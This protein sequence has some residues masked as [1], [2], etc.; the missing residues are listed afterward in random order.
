[1]DQDYAPSVSVAEDHL[2]PNRFELAQ[3]YPNPF[4]PSTT[5]SFALPTAS[6]VTVEIFNSLGQ[7]VVVL[8]EGHLAAGE[9]HVL[10]D[11]LGRDG[12]TATTGVYFCRL[13][14]GSFVDTK[15]MLLL[16]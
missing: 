2:V 6:H 5:I 9:H 1:V 7:R 12:K 3:N 13:Q 4:N 15:K 16:K 10:W 8:A 11:G 14:A